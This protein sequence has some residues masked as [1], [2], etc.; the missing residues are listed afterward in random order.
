MSVRT[1]KVLRLFC[2]D[3]R[4][5]SKNLNQNN[6]NIKN[7]L[8]LSI[9]VF[10]MSCGLGQEM[11]F[12]SYKEIDSASI[13]YHKRNQVDSAIMIIEY[14]KERYPEHEENTTAILGYLYTKA[15]KYD[16]ALA[17]W[18]YGTN[19]GYFYGLN[20]NW[21]YQNEYKENPVFGELTEKD[22]L[23]GDSLDRLSHLKYEVVLPSDY[24]AN[25]TYPVLFIFHG[26][27][28]NISKSKKNWDSPVLGK[29]YIAV[30]VQ[31]YSHVSIYDFKWKS[32][33]IKTIDEF[34]NIYDSITV[35][36]PID[37]NHILFAGMSAGGRTVLEFAFNSIVPMNGLILNC[38]VI[39]GGIDNEKISSFISQG[40][41]LAMIT[42][43]KDWAFEDQ[44]NLI[45]QIDAVGSECRFIVNP[46]KGHEFTGKFPAQLDE[47]LN[48]IIK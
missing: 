18:K 4:K 20:Y 11:R 47:C 25:L 28:R 5:L 39:P 16:K 36:Y 42:G 40:K 9:L 41:R 17:C 2:P 35:S 37:R 26:N 38:P 30:F 15:K 24:N 33:D 12:S 3:F 48:W 29:N 32:N 45:T 19:K 14:A 8:S 7:L 13:E 23:N 43:D 10:S 27:S 22:N 21:Y 1:D 6:M 44:K 34:K 31:S 46:D